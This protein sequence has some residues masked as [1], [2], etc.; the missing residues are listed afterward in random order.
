[1]QIA[2]GSRRKNC[3]GPDLTDLTWGAASFFMCSHSCMLRKLWKTKARGSHE[4][5]CTQGLDLSS[6]SCGSRAEGADLSSC[7]CASAV[8]GGEG[9]GTHHK[10]AGQTAAHACV[11]V[12]LVHDRRV[13]QRFETPGRHANLICCTTGA[14]LR[15][16]VCGPLPPDKGARRFVG[17]AGGR[18]RGAHCQ[19]QEERQQRR[20]RV[21][22]R[23]AHR[24]CAARAAGGMHGFGSTI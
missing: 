19:Q 16:Y 8:E 13:V 15:R 22:R 1:M 10:A 2:L 7:S 4:T 11:T 14:H 21:R 24:A 18:A 12:R 17:G 23:A 3:C 20:R 6:G 5:T 9:A